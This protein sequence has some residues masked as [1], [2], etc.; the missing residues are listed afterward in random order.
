MRELELRRV[1]GEEDTRAAR[2]RGGTAVS[3]LA[4]RELRGTGSQD[5]FTTFPPTG[6]VIVASGTREAQPQLVR[7]KLQICT[8]LQVLEPVDWQRGRKRPP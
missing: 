6:G 7:G 1:V 5:G 3:V 2:G 8:M 4:P